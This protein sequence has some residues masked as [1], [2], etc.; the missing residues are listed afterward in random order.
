MSPIISE[1]LGNNPLHRMRNRIAAGILEE[2]WKVNYLVNKKYFWVFNNVR[3]DSLI[4]DNPKAVAV[5]VGAGPSLGRNIDDLMKENL[6][7]LV[8]FST[9]KAFPILSEVGVSPRFVCALNAK[10]PDGECSAWWQKG[11]TK[12]STLIMP[13]TADPKH[14]DG[15]KGKYCLI[16]CFLPVD[17]TDQITAEMKLDP[18]PGGSNVGVFS[19]LMAAKLEYKTIILLGMDYSFESR[20][21]AIKKYAP[22]EPYLIIEHRDKDGNIRWTSWDWYDSAIAFFEYAGFFARNGVRTINASDGGI[23]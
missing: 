18:I 19:Y 23:I 15:W 16:N 13:M 10:S 6:E 12:D 17:L 5:V 1:R 11:Q 14:L 21:Q 2:Q 4:C 3:L 20:E 7:N 22:G 8:F 9:D